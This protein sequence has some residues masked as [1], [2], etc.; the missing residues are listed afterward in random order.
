MKVL[1]TGATGFVGSHVVDV[2]LARGID[3]SYIARATS[4]HRWLEGKPVQ[5]V[6]G[7]LYDLG[8]LK[9]ALDGVDVVIHVAGQTAGRSEEDFRRGNQVATQNLIDAVRS[10]RPNLQRF[11]HISSMA[12]TGPASS[13]GE[14]NTESSPLR[15]ITAY[16]RTKKLAE[17][18][19]HDAMGDIPCTI[20]RPP[21]VYG[22]RDEA[23][24]TFFASVAKGL[25]PL[26]GFDNKKVSLVHIR[27][28]ARGIAD[29]SFAETA[30]GQTYF[31]SS[32]EW[33]TWPQI[34]DVT[35]TVVGRKRLFTV[36]LP[37]PLVL[38]IAGTSGAFGRFAKKPPVLDYE[39]GI[40][41][42]QSYWICTTD[43]ARRD[44]GY[45]QQVSLEEGILE[46]VTW[47]REQGWL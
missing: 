28:L 31:V 11:V 25:A 37:H 47:Y 12:V 2:L 44:F 33:Y 3:V 42:I 38:A 40:D 21:A 13:E 9:K 18:V 30:V 35:A 27:D 41:M 39:K 10:Y 45:R 29:A 46:T 34:A 1:V 5:L 16:G 8:S 7:S 20:I 6:E 15:P 4:N 32:D 23:T 22:P 19:I 24:L 14:P 26:I 17:E 36:R 43:K